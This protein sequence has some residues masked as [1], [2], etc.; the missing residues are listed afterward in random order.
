MSANESYLNEYLAAEERAEREQTPIDV[1]AKQMLVYALRDDK[2]YNELFDGYQ[3]AFSNAELSV[4]LRNLHAAKGGN[5]SAGI[6]ILDRIAA[7]ELRCIDCL[8]HQIKDRE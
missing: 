4:M 1:E 7:F 8:R 2:D 5:V 3:L 6:A